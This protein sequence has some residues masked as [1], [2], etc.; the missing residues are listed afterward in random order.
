MQAL[1]SAVP[2]KTETKP[3]V[4]RGGRPPR[5]LAG[6]VDERILDAAY[7]VFMDRGLNG[8]SIDEIARLARAGKPTIYARF[9]TKEALFAA[10]G[11]RNAA[12]VTAHLGGYVSA[13]PTFEARL[14]ALGKNMLERLLADEV[15]DFMRLSA[16]EARRVPELTHFGRNARMRGAMAALEALREA[17]RAADIR[18]F[19]AFGPE[20]IESTAAYFLDLVVGPLLMRALVGEDPVQ[21]RAEIESHVAPR[22]AFLLTACR[23]G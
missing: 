14:V 16:A 10:V 22:V 23:V 12:R 13:G 9:P 8:A 2:K 17:T 15:I 19:P 3:A 5:E 20:H 11:M 21:L 6:E 1:K 18:R 7:Q 4:N